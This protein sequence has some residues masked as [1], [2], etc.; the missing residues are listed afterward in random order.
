V[1]RVIAGEFR[2]RKL[3]T[4]GGLGTRP[5]L[6]RVRE[7][8]FNVLQ[9]RFEGAEV[10]D[11][12]AGTGANGIEAL[13]R[14]AGRVVFVE[15]AG[16]A[17]KVLRANLEVLSPEARARA[18]V[19]RADAW[20][21]PVVPGPEGTET[22]PDLLF[23]DPPY[24]LVSLDPTLA[25]QRL[26]VLL[27]R[28]A[29]DAVAVFHFPEG[30]IDEDDLEEVGPTDLRTWGSSAVAFVQRAELAGTREASPPGGR[31]PRED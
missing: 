28:S 23:V 4:A 31:D 9:G 19:L 1:I 16:P 17:L 26:E 3:R 5:F 12:F 2:G 21:P 10:W 24:S 14:G 22:P 11:L 7:S 29:P 13:S 25:L 8:V 30:L 15:K 27:G 18:T 6:D 20:D